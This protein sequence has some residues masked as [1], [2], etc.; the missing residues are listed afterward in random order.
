MNRGLTAVSMLL[1]LFACSFSVYAHGPSGQKVVKEFK[2]NAPPGRVWA[3]L[4]DF[5]AIHQWHPDVAEV[6]MEA[7]ADA[8]TGAVLPHRWMKLKD[9]TTVLEKLREVNDAEMKLDYKMID[10]AESSIAVSNYRTVAQVKQGATANES[11]VIL[12]ARFYNKA[13]TME[14]PPGADNP[15]ANKAINALYDAAAVGMQAILS[16]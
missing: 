13:N 15:A 2:V 5:G 7:R 4:K 1:M 8:E 12:T 6:K 16:Q 11:I 14:A 9:G 10:G 3:L